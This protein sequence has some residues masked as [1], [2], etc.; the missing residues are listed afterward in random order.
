MLR[1]Q[2]SD[3]RLYLKRDV[4]GRGL[5]SLE[6]I[7]VETRLRVACCMVKS[8][9][10]WIKAVWKR[11]LLKETN[12]IKEE[13]ITSMHAV[14]SVLDF[15]EDWILQDGERIEKHWELI[16]RAI[17]ARL[18]K[19]VERKRR[20]EYLDKQMQRGIFRKQDESCNLWLR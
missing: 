19:G 9:N 13:A 15:E 14:R 6:D 11:E 1:R 16:W 10:K 18:R 8:S 17:K 20:E 5:K 12:S 2:S 4:G 3:E 7:L